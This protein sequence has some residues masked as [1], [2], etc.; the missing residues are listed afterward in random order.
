MKVSIQKYIAK[1][2][3]VLLIT[4]CA[5]QSGEKATHQDILQDTTSNEMA[6]E[7]LELPPRFLNILR[8]E[9]NQLAGGMGA[10]LSYMVRGQGDEA[11][12]IAMNIHNSYILKQELTK[13]ELNELVSL[14]PEKF[15]KLDRGFHQLAEEIATS[16]KN[17][18]FEKSGKIYGQMVN[19][20]LNCHMQ[21]ATE[22][23]PVFGK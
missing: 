4:G 10:M 3:F 2:L 7:R 1:F 18:E 16:L 13:E 11:A 9:M 22:R 20:C 6:G 8:Q 14:L 15:I 5:D 19:A 17:K 21:F 12:E 23:F